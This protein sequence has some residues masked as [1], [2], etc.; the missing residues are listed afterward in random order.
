MISS[1]H[2]FP[3]GVVAVLIIRIDLIGYEQADLVVEVKGVF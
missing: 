2:R 3:Q 1:C